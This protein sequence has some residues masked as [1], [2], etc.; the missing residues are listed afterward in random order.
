MKARMIL[1]AILLVIL[2]TVSVNA[3]STELPNPPA[4]AAPA[5]ERIMG[6][7]VFTDSCKKTVAAVQLIST[8]GNVKIALIS[9]MPQKDGDEIMQMIVDMANAGIKGQA[10]ELYPNC[11]KT[12]AVA[13]SA[14]L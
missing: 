10:V 11:L 13:G 8:W 14:K 7:I 3:P 9:T 4:A 5:P 12:S 1:A 2:G 6:W